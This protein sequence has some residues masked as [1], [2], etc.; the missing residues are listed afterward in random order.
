MGQ[1][2]CGASPCSTQIALPESESDSPPSARLMKAS[3]TWEIGIRSPYF[4]HGRKFYCEPNTFHCSA[5]HSEKR[6]SFN[7]YVIY[8][9]VD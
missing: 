5:V 2:T 9:S 8:G 1:Y 7:M 6:A 4:L 3:T